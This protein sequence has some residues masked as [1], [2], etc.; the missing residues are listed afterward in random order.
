MGE[1]TLHYLTSVS[2]A[3]HSFVSVFKMLSVL[4]MA[5][6]TGPVMGSILLQ[7]VLCQSAPCFLP[8]VVVESTGIMNVDLTILIDLL[9]SY[10]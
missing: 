2:C 8:Y 3:L 5:V 10:P 9:V 1:L 7:V 4:Y 6:N